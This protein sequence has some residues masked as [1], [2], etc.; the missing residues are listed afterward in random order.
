M[1]SPLK[2]DCFITLINSTYLK[3][4]VKSAGPYYYFS[5]LRQIHRCSRT[6]LTPCIISKKGGCV[7]QIRAHLPF[8]AK[9][10]RKTSKF[11]IKLFFDL[12]VKIVTFLSYFFNK[13]FP[14]K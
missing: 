11:C 9:K 5:L 10:Y 1:L 8:W 4:L 6:F 12:E 14:R 2:I 7:S 13:E 3:Y